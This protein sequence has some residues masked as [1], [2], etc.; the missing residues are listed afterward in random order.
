MNEQ[1]LLSSSPFTGLREVGGFGQPLHALYPQI[2]SVLLTESGPEV[3]DLLAEPVVDRVR[4]RI[5]WYTQGDPDQPRVLASALPEPQRQAV[6]E[7][8]QNRLEQGRQAAAHYMAAEDPR[9]AQLGVVLQAALSTPTADDV[10]LLQDRPVMIRWGFLADGPWG[11]LVASDADRTE[12]SP[13]AGVFTSV[14]ATEHGQEHD[15]IAPL[16][17]LPD[18]AGQSAPLHATEPEVGSEVGSEP[19][20]PPVAVTSTPPEPVVASAPP[21]SSSPTL[22]T[23]AVHEAKAVSSSSPERRWTFWAIIGL[24]LLLLMVVLWWLWPRDRAPA[25]TD[26]PSNVTPTARWETAPSPSQ[27]GSASAPR[28]SAEGSVS[29]PSSESLAQSGASSI[30]NSGRTSSSGADSNADSN[31]D[32]NAVTSLPPVVSSPAEPGSTPSGAAASSRT[33]D[34]ASVTDLAT[35]DHSSRT[36][37]AASRRSIDQVQGETAQSANPPLNSD[38]ARLPSPSEPITST[39]AIRR[40]PVPP[41]VTAPADSTAATTARLEEVLADQASATAADTSP[42]AARSTSGLEPSLTDQNSRLESAVRAGVA[43]ARRTEPTPEEQ[44]EFADRVSE[45]GAV[46]GEIT[47]TLLWNGHSDLDLVVQ[48]PSSQQL[49]YQ[50]PA[51]CGG[52]LDVDANTT[53]EDLSDRPVENVFW[54]ASRIAPGTYQIAVRYSPRK[55]ETAPTPTPFQ[56]RLI[57]QGQESVFKGMAPPGTISPVTTFT[58]PR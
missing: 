36:P 12:P 48:C 14:L 45:T 11:T 17:P 4:S 46:T 23:S 8:V 22:A 21:L 19:V 7:Q 41:S 55:D 50:N 31:V 32:S 24:L 2:R 28:P 20:S 6:M 10:F 3:A 40:A 47:V 35:T 33:R 30:P 9:R 16:S 56:V 1:I 25:L 57:Q 38:S 42:S 13:P 44:R 54:P 49:D 27:P 18:T 29:S 15:V 51:A 39:T 34:A 58:I 26:N 5:D 52:A 53:R 37:A 43:N